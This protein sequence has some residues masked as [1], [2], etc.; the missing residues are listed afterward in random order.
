[1][2]ESLVQF[3]SNQETPPPPPPTKCLFTNEPRSKTNSIVPTSY[4]FLVVYHQSFV[5]TP[6]NFPIAMPSNFPYV[7]QVDPILIKSYTLWY[8]END[9]FRLNQNCV[10]YLNC[11]QTTNLK[12][13]RIWMSLQTWKRFK[14]NFTM[15]LMFEALEFT[16]LLIA[17]WKYYINSPPQLISPY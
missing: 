3:L 8:I 1:M 15:Q 12:H 11:D 5:V 7:S 17:L 2:H 16:L 10:T 4:K 14:W 6:S 13:T 9:L